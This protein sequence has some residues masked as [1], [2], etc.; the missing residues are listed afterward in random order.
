MNR[1]KSWFQRQSK[2]RQYVTVIGTI[3]LLV[4][5]IASMSDNSGDSDSNDT[6]T[7]VAS[8]NTGPTSP[9]TTTTTGAEP[10]ATFLNA[11]ALVDDKQ[12][13]AAIALVAAASKSTKTRTRAYVASAIAATAIVALNSGNR[14]LASQRIRRALGFA[15]TAAVRSASSKL[16]RA[17]AR[18]SA[19]KAAKEQRAREQ[20][21]ERRRI[22]AEKQAAKD[23][24]ARDAATPPAASSSEDVSGLTCPEIGHSFNVV[25]GS[26][27][28]HDANGDG[29][30]CESQ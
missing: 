9:T 16:N 14:K 10:K 27:P 13:D 6:S 21:A 7:T 15:N 26:D 11:K 3:L 1:A 22:R 30:A 29:V 18:A 25:P 20:A 12:Y 19:R 4:V 5:V 17:Q 2:R 24:A 28:E 23:A 8:T